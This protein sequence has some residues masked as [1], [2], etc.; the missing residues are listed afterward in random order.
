MDKGHMIIETFTDEWLLD[1]LPPFF[2]RRAF[3]DGSSPV[4]GAADQLL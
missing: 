2:G 3:L 1:S 4:Q